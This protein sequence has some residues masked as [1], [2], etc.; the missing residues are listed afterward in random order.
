MSKLKKECGRTFQIVRG[1]EIRL[2]F[3]FNGKVDSSIV[4]KEE[5]IETLKQLLEF[6]LKNNNQ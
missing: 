5:D 2:E 4:L 6:T 1:V 3:L